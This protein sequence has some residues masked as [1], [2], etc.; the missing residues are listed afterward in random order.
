MD[1]KRWWLICDEDVQTIKT[2]LLAPTHEA[3]DYNCE[4]WPPGKEC[5]GCE[6]NELRQKALH[7]LESGLHITNVVP[8]DWEE[9][10]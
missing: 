7:D 10:T 8:D 1:N 5:E 9:K 6:G 4:D 3:N 2:A